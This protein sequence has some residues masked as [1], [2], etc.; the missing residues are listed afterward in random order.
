MRS[1]YHPTSWIEWGRSGPPR[2]MDVL[3]P[4]EGMGAGQGKT[5]QPSA[6]MSLQSCGLLPPHPNSPLA[7]GPLQPSRLAIPPL[8]EAQTIPAS[9][10]RTSNIFP[11]A[12]QCCLGSNS[13]V[14][15]THVHIPLG[16]EFYRFSLQSHAYPLHPF[17]WRSWSTPTCFSE[18]LGIWHHSLCCQ[19]Q[20]LP[21]RPVPASSVQELSDTI[22]PKNL[23]PD[24][25]AWHSETSPLPIWLSTLPAFLPAAA[26]Q[27]LQTPGKA[28]PHATPH[29]PPRHHHL[30]R[31][32]LMPGTSV[33]TTLHPVTSLGGILPTTLALGSDPSSNTYQLHNSRQ[34][35]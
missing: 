7:W 3:L 21:A 18:P 16:V 34:V 32:S 27:L 22:L 13:I 15:F 9:F 12:L 5:T 10:L 29:S 19:I 4:E 20:P 2:K 25:S 6:P 17:F 23:T 14:L 8:S 28:P 35:Q 31:A 26:R 1:H 24:L 11:A 33:S 30:A